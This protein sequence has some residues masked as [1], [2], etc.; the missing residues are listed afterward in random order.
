MTAGAPLVLYDAACRALAEAVRVD[1]VKEIL[2]VAV[3]MAAYA[4]QAKNRDAEADA[5]EIRMRATRRLDQMRQTQKETVGLAKGGEHGGR[6]GK[7]GVRQ[8]P[9]IVHPTL[10][11]QGIDKNLAK[12]ARAFGALS[13]QQFESVVVEARDKVARAVRNAVREVEREQNR[14]NRGSAIEDG[15]TVDDVIALAHSGKRFGVIYADPAWEFKVY[16]GKGKQRS[17]ERHYDTA[18]LDAIKALPVAPLAA[19]D[20]ALLLWNVWPEMPG[21]LDVIKAWGF[22]FKTAGFVW[23]KTVSDANPAL[24]T[25]MGYYTRAN[26][27]SC[28]LATRGS[29]LRLNAD[30]HQVVLAPVGEHSE[31]PEE[32]RRRIERLFPGPYLELYARKPAPGWS[33]WGNEIP[34]SAFSAPAPY[35]AADDF[36]KSYEYALEAKRARGD[37]QQANGS[38]P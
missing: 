25:G 11:M 15:C 37:A 10:A 35:D 20:C 19:E 8:T 22:E 13:D 14:A 1:E 21:A 30:V 18:S 34:R 2:N 38:A 28:L 4:R 26:T 6:R 33:V 3:A 23:V 12:Q 7:D 24:F 32:V 27:E 36:A 17:A 9:S 29:P 16:S 31:K 5:I